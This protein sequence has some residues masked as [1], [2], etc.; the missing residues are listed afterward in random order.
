MSI[1]ANN[2]ALNEILEA[3][4]N[5]PSADGLSSG[6]V[7]TNIVY[8]DDNTVTLTDKDGVDHTMVCEYTDGALSGLTYDGKSVELTYEE[9]VLVNIGAMEVDMANAPYESGGTE[10]LE[11]LIDQSG[12][13]DS[14]EGT[15]ED[16]VEALIEYTAL[17]GHINSLNFENNKEIERIDIYINKPYTSCDSM[18]YGTSNLKFLFGINTSTRANVKNMFKQSGIE[19]IQMPLDFSKVTAWGSATAFNEALKLREVRFEPNCLKCGYYFGSPYLSA[20]SIQSIIDA[21]S[22]TSTADINFN[23]S[24]E[25]DYERLTAEQR[26]IITNEKGWSLVFK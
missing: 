24:L 26:N 19:V 18:F 13:L 6:T 16:K 20:D 25:E 8:N 4:N 21:L 10:E 7:Y 5:L 2:A 3:I 17:F 12:V 14:T 11:T 22:T 23:L 9:D 15:V 1:N